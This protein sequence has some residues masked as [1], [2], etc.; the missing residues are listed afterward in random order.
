MVTELTAL[1]ERLIAELPPATATLNVY[2]VPRGGGPVIELRPRNSEAADF[3]VHCDDSDVY[4]FSF[5]PTSTWEF[6]YERRY[7]KGEKDVLTE[8]E[9]ISRA[10][11]EGRCDLTRNWFSLT[12]RIYVDSYVYE[13]TDL[14]MFP[15][16]PFGMRR[17]ESYAGGG[18]G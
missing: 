13:T 10:V 14:P 18:N 12:G 6:P 2:Q 16:P 4:S 11:I 5:G 17:F 3:R 8:I 7:R 9:K 1:F 15:R